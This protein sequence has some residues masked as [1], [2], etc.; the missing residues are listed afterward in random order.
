MAKVCAPVRRHEMAT[1]GGRAGG[2]APQD[3]EELLPERSV[4]SLDEYLAMQRSIG[5]RTR[6]EIVYR[7]V[8][9]GSKSPTELNEALEI[10]DSTLHYHLN[11]L[12]DVGLV[13]K[14]KRTER[15][16]DGL[17]TYYRATVLAEAILEHGIEELLRREWDFEEAYGSTGRPEVG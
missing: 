2:E 6:F 4:L 11:E 12:V 5:D 8:R 10:D 16:S 9:G 17:Y 7:L 1:E 15:N 3:P 13:E 14:R